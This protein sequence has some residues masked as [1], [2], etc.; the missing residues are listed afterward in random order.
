[1]RNEPQQNI[2]KFEIK[3]IAIGGGGIGRDLKERN[4]SEENLY[5]YQPSEVAHS[6]FLC[7][8][9]EDDDDNDAV[10]TGRKRR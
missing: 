3:D 5:F 8:L 6:W 10:G 1:M 4:R 7:S 9:K 2:N